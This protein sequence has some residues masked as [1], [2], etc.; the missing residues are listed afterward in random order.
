[1]SNPQISW[2]KW[3]VLSIAKHAQ[4]CFLNEYLFVQGLTFEKNK[5]PNRYE[6]R[7]LGPDIISQTADMSAIH[8]TLNCQISTVRSPTNIE[9]HLMRIGK[10]Q[11]FLTTCIPVYKYGSDTVLDDKSLFSQLQQ[12]S[13]VETTIL[14]TIDPVT[15]VERS[16]VEATYKMSI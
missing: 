1:M 12:I 5:P 4:T 7:Y 14:G 11:D 3:V 8:I 9:D 10:A 2:T 16:T 15:S 13:N 6:L